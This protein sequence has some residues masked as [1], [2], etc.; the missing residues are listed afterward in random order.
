MLDIRTVHRREYDLDA[1]LSQTSYEGRRA[2]AEDGAEP[3]SGEI[4]AAMAPGRLHLLG[5]HGNIGPGLFL[6]A[7]IDRHVRVAVSH[8]KDTALRFLAADAGERKRTT[9]ASLRYKREDRWAN[10]AKVAIQVFADMGLPIRGLNFT[11]SG[12]IPQQVGLASSTA[13]EIASALA[14]KKLLGAKIG[15]TELARRLRAIHGTY[16]ERDPGIADYLVGFFAR[17]RQFL[18]VDEADMSVAKIKSPFLRCRIV[19]TDSRVPRSEVENELGSRR[20]SLADALRVLAQGRARKGG[21]TSLRDFAEADIMDSM[22]N[23]SEKTRRRTLFFVQE[24]GRVSAAAEMLGRG[25]AAGFA[26]LV[27]HSHEGL[28]DLY[29]ISC[30]EIDW[31]VK[32]GQETAGVI[33]ARMAGH[34]FGGCTYALAAPEAVGDFRQRLDDYE[35]IFGFHPVLHEVAIATGA[36]AIPEAG[37]GAG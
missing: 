9:M 7:A 1:G 35:R 21:E 20:E 31:I 4:A 19:I 29:E 37:Q 13:V 5:E 14:L 16:F 26:R 18:M 10:Y 2:V 28:R 12:D 23:L 33:G 24:A 25:D 15:E 17:D 32:R 6:S 34:G 3:A 30:P 22:G 8:R 11:I 36:R 27:F